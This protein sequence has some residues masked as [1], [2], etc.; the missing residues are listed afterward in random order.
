MPV[1]PPSFFLQIAK[2]LPGLA[3]KIGDN[4]VIHQ[5]AMARLSPTDMTV[6]ILTAHTP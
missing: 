5:I 2:I 6:R 1:T 4:L 3:E